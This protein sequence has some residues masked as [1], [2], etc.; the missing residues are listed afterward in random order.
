MGYFFSEDLGVVF[1]SFSI[2]FL[3]IYSYSH[4]SAIEKV[5]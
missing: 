5:T 3:N 1:F 2:V 4:T